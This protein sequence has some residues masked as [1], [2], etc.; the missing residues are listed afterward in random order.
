MMVSLPPGLADRESVSV[1]FALPMTR[2]L[3]SVPSTVV[4]Q[5]PAR[6]GGFVVG[7]EFALIDETM[8][9]EVARYVELCAPPDGG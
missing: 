2:T 8:R 4:W 9:R 1:R 7:L 5:Q 6:T 3:V